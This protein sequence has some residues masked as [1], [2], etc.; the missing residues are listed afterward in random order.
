MSHITVY[1]CAFS[2]T[3]VGGT[4]WRRSPEYA[5][6]VFRSWS[7]DPDYDDCTL[8]RFDMELPDGISND[9]ATYIVDQEA[10]S[11]LEHE[12]IEIRLPKGD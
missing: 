9:L 11:L 5:D 6:E 3:N 8:I 1:C 4:E 7:E 12:C 2:N 10:H